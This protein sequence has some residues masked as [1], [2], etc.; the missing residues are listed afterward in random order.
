MNMNDISDIKKTSKGVLDA[1]VLLKNKERESI[2]QNADGAPQV[3]LETII[4]K[5]S[6][7]RKR[8]DKK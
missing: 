2:R 3:N 5:L 7:K 4:Q 6:A 1:I 8:Q